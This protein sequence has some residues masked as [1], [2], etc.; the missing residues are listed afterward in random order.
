MNSILGITAP[1]FLIVF[2]GYA[3]ARKNVFE[4]SA[5]KAF[6]LYVFYCAMPC[7]LFLA[8]AKTPHDMIVDH[9]Y[10][11]SYIFGMG[12]AAALGGFVTWRLYKRNGAASILGMMGACYTNS[13]FVGIPIIVM[14]FGQPGP[15]VIVTLFQ[16]I[17][18]TTL[19]LTG[20]EAYR[21]HGQFSLAAFYDLPKA[22]FLNPI[23]GG[24]LLGILFSLY[25][26][27]LPPVLFRTFELLGNAGIPTAL[28]ALGLSLGSP[29]Q[30]LSD[31]SRGLVYFLTGIKAIIHPAAAWALGFYIFNLHEPWLG[32]LVVVSAMPTA[33]NNFIFAQRYGTFEAESS[34]VVFLSSVISLFT[35]SGILW[36]IGIG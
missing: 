13:A 35:L 20:L 31:E 7:Y 24:S 16:V 32:A 36:W 9:G 27:S 12:F 15:V 19:I 25:G 33:M 23:V 5:Q 17:V 10:I 21:K 8:M 29:R 2:L 30:P 3:C 6:S 34:Q 22:V 1:V 28:F 11:L 26:L 18:V 14:A 4:L